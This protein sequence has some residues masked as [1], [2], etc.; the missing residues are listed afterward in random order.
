[1]KLNKSPGDDGILAEFYIEYWYLI[2]PEFM[3][4]V[5]HI[6]DN[7]T[8]APSQYRAILTLQKRWTRKYS[9]LAS[10]II[11]KYRLQNNY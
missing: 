5:K 2:K 10:H 7:S 1:M 8:L 9:K 11:I 4:M 3:K 6:F